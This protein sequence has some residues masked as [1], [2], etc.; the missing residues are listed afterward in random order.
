[1]NPLALSWKLQKASLQARSGTGLVA[2]LAV[3]SLTV[4]S[5]IAFIVAG[6]TWMFYQ[7]TLHVP[8]FPLEV[9]KS[10]STEDLMFFY[11]A[12]AFIACAFL[13]PAIFSLTSQAAVM[14]A[15]GREQRLAALRLLGMSSRQITAM[16]AAE[17]GLQA[18][19][20]IVL[21]GLLALLTAPLGS[22]FTFH[23]KQV[24]TAEL[25]LP[26]WG[27]LTVAVILLLLAL[28]SSYV[29]MQRVRVSP[30]GV[31]R[32]DMPRALRWW[33]L[34]LAVVVLIA[35]IAWMKVQD[36]STDAEFLV[37][38]FFVLFIMVSVLNVGVPFL[39]QLLFRVFGLF[40]GTSNFVATRR[41]A[42]DA[43]SAWRRSATTAFY[44]VLVG[45]LIL[46]PKGQ[47]DISTLFKE[48]ADVGMIFGDL[49]TG[50]MITV[51]IGF[52]IASVSIVLGQAAEV[53][54]RADL[55]RALADLGVPRGFHFRIALG[56]VMAPIMLVSLVGFMVGAAIMVALF[57]A[58]GDMNVPARLL[59]ASVFLLA[60]WSLTLLAML[61]VEPLRSRVLAD[62]GRRND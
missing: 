15:S 5:W 57:G 41:V 45:V 4:C 26:W 62:G 53:F 30:L 33:R 27:Y 31:A 37:S 54:E 48:E 14:G 60:G 11:L 49:N 13:F 52:I 10:R 34:I 32:R 9:H 46:S 39:L 51:V 1:M 59:N 25:I 24:G 18:V 22:N 21:G 6:G 55:S 16:T 28:L 40:P 17:T 2:F 23:L 20:G 47:D 7:R 38:L 35:G 42:T 36:V 50:V 56:Q 61:A 43:R 44:G 8:E 3:F 29:G 19:V 12:L 58:A